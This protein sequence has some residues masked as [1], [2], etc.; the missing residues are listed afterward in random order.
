MLGWINTKESL[1]TGETAQWVKSCHAS[2]RTRVQLPNTHVM[3]G[4]MVLL[5]SPSPEGW[6][7]E[8]FRGSLAGQSS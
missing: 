5:W 4:T 8:G 1:R 3:L 2:T 6:A 7:E